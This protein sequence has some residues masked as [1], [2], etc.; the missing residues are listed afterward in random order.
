[1]ERNLDLDIGDTND[2]QFEV[3]LMEWNHSG[4]DYGYR[5]FVPGTE[6]GLSLIHI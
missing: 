2:F 6:Y 1:M 4:L 3:S 5:L